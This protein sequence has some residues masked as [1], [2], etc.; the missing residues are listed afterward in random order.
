MSNTLGHFE[1]C[2]REGKKMQQEK[3]VD[4]DN[5]KPLEKRPGIVFVGSP[6]VGKRTLLSRMPFSISLSLSAVIK[7]W[8][9]EFSKI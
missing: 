9:L 6:N 4:H 8:L 7:L 2:H 3:D 1:Y 5:Q